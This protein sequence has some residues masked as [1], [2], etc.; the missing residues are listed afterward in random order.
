[1]NIEAAL[2]ADGSGGTKYWSA[3][4]YIASRLHGAI[5]F[6]FL[7]VRLWLGNLAL[8]M[9][10]AQLSSYVFRLTNYL[11]QKIQPLYAASQTGPIDKNGVKTLSKARFLTILKN[12]IG[13]TKKICLIQH[14]FLFEKAKSL[15]FS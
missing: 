14:R 12:P 9:R 7:K 6:N 2:L 10:F 15:A 11:F 1:M 13:S 3:K 5:L 8:Q 4:T